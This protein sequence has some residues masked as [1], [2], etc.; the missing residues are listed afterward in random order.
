MT[1]LRE[2]LLPADGLPRGGLTAQARVMVMAPHPDDETLGAGGVLQRAVAARAAVRV[3]FA[4][5]GENNPWPQRVLERRWRIG[6]GERARWASRR[7]A[8]ALAAL[9]V[10]G[11]ASECVDFL[12]LPD[13][14]LT[15]VLLRED[16]PGAMLAAEIHDWRP[17]LIVGPSMLDLHPDHS[18]LAILLEL[19]L[20][21]IAP[22][23]RCAQLAY[24]IHGPLRAATVGLRLRS[25]ERRR[26]ETAL[27][28]HA[29]QLLFHHRSFVDRARWEN[30]V[31][32]SA[33][34]PGDAEHPLRGIRLE[35]RTSSIDLVIRPRWPLIPTRL[36]LIGHGFP[37]GTVRRTVPLP[38]RSGWVPV[39]DSRSDRTVAR[40]ALTHGGGRVHLGVP[41]GALARSDRLF[42]KLEHRTLFFD[43]AGWRDVLLQPEEPGRAVRHPARGFHHHLASGRPVTGASG[44]EPFPVG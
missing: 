31:S 18:A 21:S 42:L 36:H 23:H 17:T 25:A 28:C 43:T 7:R 15:E 44:P 11:V 1:T 37:R 12:G 8:E 24:L 30:F 40:A 26:K 29:S 35:G 5:D 39:R 34:A 16:D 19:A 4:T 10:L 27:R 2:V 33:A 14:R 22:A 9:R 41:L 32:H 3:L 38:L 20:A 6:A 13:Q